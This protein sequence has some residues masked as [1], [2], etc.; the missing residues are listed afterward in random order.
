MSQPSEYSILAEAAEQLRIG[1]Q[2]RIRRA[3]L[4]AWFNRGGEAASSQ[5]PR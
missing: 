5:D 3:D 2:R 1:E 4:D